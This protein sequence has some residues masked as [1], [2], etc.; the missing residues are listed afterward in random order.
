M[1]FCSCGGSL[2]SGTPSKQRFIEDGS[3]LVAVQYIADDGTYNQI[4]KDDVIDQAY[5]DAKINHADPS[6][7]WIPY[8]SFVNVDESR[9][10]P[11]TESFSDGSSV[12]VQNSPRVWSGLLNNYSPQYISNLGAQRCQDFGLFVINDCGGLQ[13]SVTAD[14][15]FLRPIRVNNGSWYPNYIK[16]TDTVSAKVSLSFEFSQLENDASLR[17]IEKGE[18]D[19]VDLTTIRGLLDVT[20]T[21]SAESTTGFVADLEIKFDTFLTASKVSA[22]GWLLADFDLKLKS[23]NSPIVITSVDEAPD[24]TY[25]FVIPTQASAAVLILTTVKAGFYLKTEITIP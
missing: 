11:I 12:V 16:K 19:G 24:G 20:P 15:E 9:A 3:I 5:I 10:D 4:G 1:S 14:G 8:G 23:D 25:T 2:N 22:K 6:K 7:R 17:V 13:G 18:M 21:I